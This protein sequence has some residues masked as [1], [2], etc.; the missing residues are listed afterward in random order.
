[1]DHMSVAKIKNTCIHMQM[2]E[3]KTY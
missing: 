2:E 3:G 1:V